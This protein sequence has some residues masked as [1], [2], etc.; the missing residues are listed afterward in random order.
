MQQSTIETA[1][2]QH[3]VEH[4]K[5]ILTTQLHK[6]NLVS[7]TQDIYDFTAHYHFRAPSASCRAETT[8]V[9]HEEG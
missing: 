4:A 5:E 9:A 6:A 2:A 8:Q 1:S 7:V 3:S